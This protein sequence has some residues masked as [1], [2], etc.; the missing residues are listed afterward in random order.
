ML[1]THEQWEQAAMA[2]GFNYDRAHSMV[3]TPMEKKAITAKGVNWQEY[4]AEIDG[5]LNKIEKEKVTRPPPPGLHVDPQAAIRGDHPHRHH[6]R[7]HNK[8]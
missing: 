5:Y 6:H 2:R 1:G 8:R 4:T 3:A 7:S